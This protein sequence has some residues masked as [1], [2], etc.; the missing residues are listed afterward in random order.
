MLFVPRITFLVLSLAVFSTGCHS[1]VRVGQQAARA[2][3]TIGPKAGRSIGH[4]ALMTVG[5][6]VAADVYD[7]AKEPPGPDK[8]ARNDK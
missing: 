1:A 2:A 3:K 5:S 7:A 8:P 4:G 6:K